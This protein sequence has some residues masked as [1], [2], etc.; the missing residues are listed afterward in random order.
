MYDLFSLPCGDKCSSTLS[1]PFVL[2]A[3]RSSS[4]RATL[5]GA[6]SIRRLSLFLGVCL[7]NVIRLT[8]C[9]A[10]PSSL[11]SWVRQCSP[12]EC[13]PLLPFYL[14]LLL[15]YTHSSFSFSVMCGTYVLL[16]VFIV[17]FC[18]G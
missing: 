9:L 17:L 2:F 13:H 11:F 18:A 1:P 14:R 4:L 15:T 5:F 7:V 10:R 6:S 12:V 16:L 3:A 8:Q